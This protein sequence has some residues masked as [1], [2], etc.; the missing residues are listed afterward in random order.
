MEF[1]LRNVD[2]KG[3]DLGDALLDGADLRGV[4]MSTFQ[5]HGRE[6]RGAKLY[7]YALFGDRLKQTHQGMTTRKRL[8]SANPML[9]QERSSPTQGHWVKQIKKTLSDQEA[10]NLSEHDLLAG[11]DPV[12]IRRLFP[13]RFDFFI[14]RQLFCA[15]RMQA[16]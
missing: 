1:V 3:P 6:L 16:S 15:C 8:A 13:Q 9:I 11:F 12:N 14:S 2:L 5:L 7:N 4:D 10:Y